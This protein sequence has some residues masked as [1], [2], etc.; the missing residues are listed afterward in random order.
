M[1]EEAKRLK[2]AARWLGEREERHERRVR[3]TI[4][5]LAAVLIVGAS[6]A[7]C[8]TRP[9]HHGGMEA[10][11]SPPEFWATDGEQPPGPVARPMPAKPFKG[12]KKPPCGKRDVALNGGC[13]REMAKPP[14]PREEC[15]PDEFLH[16]G[17]CYLPVQ[18]AKRPPTSIEP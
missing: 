5:A 11:E 6:I 16:G 4:A 1:E 3:R 2:A 13:W 18:E 9:K 15:G 7:G 10:Q 12:Q 17:K 8:L 14:D